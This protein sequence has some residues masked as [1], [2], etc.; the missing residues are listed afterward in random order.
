[1]SKSALSIFDKLY[2]TYN[3][4]AGKMLIHTGVIG[5]AL[6]SAAQIAAIIFND[7]IPKE[8]KMFLIPQE[9]MDACVNVI[10][11]YLVT[12]SFSTI[13]KKLAKTGKWLPSAVKKYMVKNNLAKGLGTSAFD[14]TKVKLPYKQSR[15]YKLFAHGLDVVATTIGSIISCNIITPIFRNMYAS[16]R[17]KDNIAKFNSTE[18]TRCNLLYS[19]R[20]A[21]PIR[22]AVTKPI[23]P[24]SGPL[25]V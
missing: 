3:G 22:R 21:C 7:K 12:Q 20:G 13:A 14:M 24:S 8:Q 5:W 10:S 16:K 18:N 2:K 15:N 25:K 11:F 9:F 6:S 19:D 4:S 17:Q 23:T 1:M